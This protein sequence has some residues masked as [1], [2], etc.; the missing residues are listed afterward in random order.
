MNAIFYFTGTGNSL[1]A[2]REIAAALGDT[3]LAG[4]F[5][6]FGMDLSGY[7]RIGFA[8]PIYFGGVPLIV[9]EFVQSLKIPEAAYLF[10]VATYSGGEWN[11]LKELNALLKAKG[12]GLDYGT[13]LQM[14]SNYILLYGRQENADSKNT[15]AAKKLAAIGAAIRDKEKL[16]CGKAN[17]L[18]SLPAWRFKRSVRKTALKYDVSGN[19]SACGLCAKI[20]P[21]RNIEIKE[22]TPV[23]GG[24]CERCM[25][26]LQW[27]PQKAV[28]YRGKTEQRERYRHPDVRAKDLARDGWQNEK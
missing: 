8:Y 2:A 25:A 23:F 28:N 17:P 26:C 13:V 22:R 14:G 10:A 5:D 20:C 4:V 12:R 18:M 27:C 16:P 15:A 9:K 7:E 3:K 6:S 1:K 11:G 24:H 21:V 19:C